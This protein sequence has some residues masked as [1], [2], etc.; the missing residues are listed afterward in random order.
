M[1]L[2]SIS[3]SDG[4]HTPNREG[5]GLTQ[6][7]ERGARPLAFEDDGW[8]VEIDGLDPANEAWAGT[9][10]ALANGVIGVRGTIEERAHDAATTFLAHAFEVSPIHYHERFAGFAESTDTRV[11]VAE[12]LGID[13]DVDGAPIDFRAAELLDC[14]RRLDLRSA[15]LTRSSRWRLAG[16]RVLHVEAVR[17][18]PLRGEAILARRITARLDDGRPVTIRPRIEPASQAAGQAD[19]PRIGVQ[20]ASSGFA[21]ESA[22][23]ALV[24]RLAGSGIGVACAQR[25]GVASGQCDIFTAYA[26]GHEPAA[27]LASRAA[28]LAERVE[29]E[30]FDRLTAAE[31]DAM[32]AFWS[33]AA[34]GTDDQRTSGALRL[35]LFHLFR[36]AGR[37]GLSSAA[38]KGLTGEGYEGHYFWDTEAFMLPVLAVLAPEIAR[39]MLEYRYRTLPEA[40]ENARALNHERGALYAWRT[41]RGRECSAHYPSS[42]AEYHVNAAIGFAIGMYD[43]ATGDTEFLVSMG[44][45]MLVETSRLWLSLGS[46]SERTGEFCI[47]GVTGPDEYTALIDN[48]WYTNRMVQKQLRLTCDVVRRVAAADPA[49]WA[50]IAPRIGF[51]DAELDAFTRAADA[52]RLPYDAELDLDAQDDSFLKKPRWDLAG[53]P[54]EKFPLL[55]HYHPMTLYRHQVAKQADLVLGLVLAGEDV[56][57][58][59]KRRDFDHYESVTAHDST[60]SASTF[61]ILA[62]EV[63]RADMALRFFRD[64]TFVDAEDLHGNASHGVHMASMA[65]SWLALVW[66]F[67]GFRPTGAVPDFAPVLPRG[68]RGY[69]FGLLWRGAELRVEVGADGAAYRNAGGATA[70]FRHNGETVELAAGSSW[71]GAL[72]AQ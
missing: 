41:I 58:D 44:A 50:E 42:S 71:R 16:G 25:V 62:S 46:W 7:H 72:R 37:D 61:S 10:L 6:D 13:M 24:Q 3:K 18:V 54:R 34:L 21:T 26:A 49:R 5:A 15:S 52:M 60:L 47:N 39:A 57:L 27:L 66:G 1:S 45:E 14:R 2:K 28:E 29:R 38:A 70:R 65:G 23:N 20:L 67:G 33:R 19:D 68:W 43:L 69:R 59:R 11:P 64:A 53:T 51:E 8:T 63:G 32:E 12:P 4:G 56:P 55:L 30:G 36:S 35:N 40:V 22:G 48:N 31:R 9:V 17:L